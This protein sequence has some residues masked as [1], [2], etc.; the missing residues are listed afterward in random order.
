[1]KLIYFFIVAILLSFS[2]R[3]NSPEFFSGNVD[4]GINGCSGSTG[5]VYII[6]YSDQNNREDSLSTLT[7]PTQFK[8]S[9]TKIKF[10]MRDL[11]N[12][13]EIMFC[14]AM[15]TPPKQKVIYNVKSQ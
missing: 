14:N 7:L 15:I 9:G 5:F 4:R 13:D 6:K 1:M 10:Q 12:T 11:N 8:L 2:C 3:K